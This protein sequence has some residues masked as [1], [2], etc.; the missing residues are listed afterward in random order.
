MLGRNL[1]DA[2]QRLFVML[3]HFRRQIAIP[4]PTEQ[5]VHTGATKDSRWK[6]IHLCVHTRV[7][8]RSKVWPR[9]LVCIPAHKRKQTKFGRKKRSPPFQV[10]LEMTAILAKYLEKYL[11]PAPGFVVPDFVAFEIARVTEVSELEILSLSEIHAGLADK[12]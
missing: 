2:D 7:L 4:A 3:C 9:P 10:A 11:A 12:H 5:P 6:P 8:D 1:V